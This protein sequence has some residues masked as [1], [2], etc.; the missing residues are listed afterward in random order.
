MLLF[1]MVEPKSQGA[2]PLLLTSCSHFAMFFSF[3]MGIN[4]GPIEMLE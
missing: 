1:I 3:E 4:F 2:F